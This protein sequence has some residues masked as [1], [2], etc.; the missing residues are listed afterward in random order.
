MCTHLPLPCINYYHGATREETE[1]KEE[2]VA[3]RIGRCVRTGRS[4]MHGSAEKYWIG[5]QEI[6]NRLETE[7][8]MAGKGTSGW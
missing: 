5:D 7:N 2:D 4:R 3:V 8:R 1:K 6:V